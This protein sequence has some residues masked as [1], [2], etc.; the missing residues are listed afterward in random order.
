M[1]NNTVNESGLRFD[2]SVP[3]K[4]IRMAAPEPNGEDSEQ[5]EVIDDKITCRL[6]QR[7]ARYVVLKYIQPVVKRTANQQIVTHTAP[8]GLF[9]KSIAD[10]SFI[11]GM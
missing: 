4:E 5:Y 2:E 1:R 10:V 8:L 9:D 3:V 11:T 6:A 7:P